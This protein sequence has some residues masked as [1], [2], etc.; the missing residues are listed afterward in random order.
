MSVPLC[1]V[2][3]IAA[4]LSAVSST[5]CGELLPR[6]ASSF[7]RAAQCR[8]KFGYICMYPNYHISMPVQRPFPCSYFMNSHHSCSAYAYIGMCVLQCSCTP[9]EL[10]S[11]G[12]MRRSSEMSVSSSTQGTPFLSLWGIRNTWCHTGIAQC[13]H[14][15]PYL[16]FGCTD[17]SMA[18]D[19]YVWSTELDIS[20]HHHWAMMSKRQTPA[21][22]SSRCASWQQTVMHLI[23]SAKWKKAEMY[24]MYLRVCHAVDW[25]YDASSLGG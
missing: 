9:W 8:P 21:T 10:V 23:T 18:Q 14:E 5:W 4:A 22:L 19:A 6:Y 11:E 3:R 25:G 1:V 20:R 2:F 16:L 24:D 15:R 7:A 12:T 13:W 17:W